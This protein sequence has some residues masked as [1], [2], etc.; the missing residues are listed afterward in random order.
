MAVIV[1]SPRGSQDHVSPCHGDLFAL[2]SCEALRAL[3]DESQCKGRV[4]VCSGC[5]TRVDDLQASV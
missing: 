3:Y 5:L 1:P 2:H 4:S